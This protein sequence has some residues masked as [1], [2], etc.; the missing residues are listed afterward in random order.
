MA[1]KYRTEGGYIVLEE[2][3]ELLKEKGKEFGSWLSEETSDFMGSLLGRS[4]K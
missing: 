3:K 1:N 2:T 4:K